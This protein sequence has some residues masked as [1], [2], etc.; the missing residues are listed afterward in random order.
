MFGEK[1]EEMGMEV[2]QSPKYI[3]SRDFAVK[4]I[5]SG[6]YDLEEADFWIL[7]NKTKSNKMMYSGLI[8]S[9]NGCLK[10]NDKLEDKFDPHCVTLDKDGYTGS[11]VYTYCDDEVYE[12]GEV[13]PKNCTNSYPYAMALKRCFDRVV[14]K[15]SKLAFHGVYSDSEA[16]EFQAPEKQAEQKKEEA[17]AKIQAQEQ[18]DKP[19]TATEI[20]KLEKLIR[21][22][23]GEDPFDVRVKKCCSAY[24]VADL[25]QLKKSQFV[26]L[27]GK[28]TK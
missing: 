14:L 16:E 21:D 12:V 5:N 15:K 18:A 9:H 24:G 23:D 25:S 4:L 10:I 28:L 22:R 20:K 26:H 27:C 19:I 1:R 13:S 11:L 17:K 7:M 3:S 8:I 6:K 2:W